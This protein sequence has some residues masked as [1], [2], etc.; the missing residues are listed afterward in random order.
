M[1]AFL[2]CGFASLIFLATFQNLWQILTERKTH[3]SFAHG[4]EEREFEKIQRRGLETLATTGQVALGNTT[5]LLT[6]ALPVQLTWQGHHTS[7]AIWVLG[8]PAEAWRSRMVSI[9]KEEMDKS[10]RTSG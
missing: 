7:P 6:H 1:C 9:A 10:A 3:S 8:A 2:L 5:F 4:R